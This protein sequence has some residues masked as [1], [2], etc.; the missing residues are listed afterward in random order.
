[1]AKVPFDTSL[2]LTAKCASNVQGAHEKADAPSA[3]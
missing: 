3:Y 1:M 2:G